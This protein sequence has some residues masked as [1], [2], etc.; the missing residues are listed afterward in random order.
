MRY[1]VY[2]VYSD[3]AEVQAAWPTFEEAEAAYQRAITQHPLAD[4]QLNDLEKSETLRSHPH[5][6]L[7]PV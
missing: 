7:D 1:E 6:H 2:V 3:G 4:V 5:R